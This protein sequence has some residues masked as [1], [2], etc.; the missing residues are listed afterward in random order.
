MSLLSAS[1]L[2]VGALAQ[3]GACFAALVLRHQ[4]VTAVFGLFNFS[5]QMLTGMFI[6]MQVL[7]PSLRTIGIVALPQSFGM[8]LLRHYVMGTRTVIA[9]PYE[10]AVL[11][12]QIA[13]YGTN[14]QI[15]STLACVLSRGSQSVHR[16][17][18]VICSTETRAEFTCG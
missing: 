5:F 18:L 13:L 6:P 1:A 11:V 4:Q 8:D 16:D 9:L 7:P 2:S 15:S 17:P 10:W 14:V 3:M 12:G